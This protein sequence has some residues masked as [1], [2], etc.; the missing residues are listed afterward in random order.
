MET[1]VELADTI[2]VEAKQVAAADGTTLRELIEEGL[3]LVPRERRS[4]HPYS[5]PDA[6]FGGRGLQ[7]GVREGGWASLPERGYEG[8]GG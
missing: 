8:R 6:S 7:P 3:R 5:L 2:V 1:T 4:R